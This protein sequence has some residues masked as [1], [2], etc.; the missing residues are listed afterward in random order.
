MDYTQIQE[1]QYY[2]TRVHSDEHLNSLSEKEITMGIWAHK[3]SA[4]KGRELLHNLRNKQKNAF[5]NIIKMF[6]K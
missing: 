6:N 3:I 1:S 5:E 2:N 4:V